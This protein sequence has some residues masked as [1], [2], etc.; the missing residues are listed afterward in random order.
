MRARRLRRSSAAVLTAALTTVLSG[1]WHGVQ[2]D[3]RRADIAF[4]PLPPAAWNCSFSQVQRLRS[5][6]QQDVQ[7]FTALLQVS[8][9]SL[10]LVG[11]NSLGLRL[12]ELS[13]SADG[14]LQLQ[15]RV[16]LPPEFDPAWVLRDLQLASAPVAALR[17]ALAPGWS[18]ETN[19]NGER[20]L[21]QQGSTVIT[22]RQTRNPEGQQEL[23]LWNHRH[24]YRLAVQT[25]QHTPADNR[26]CGVS[27]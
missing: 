26:S 18:L 20:V 27:E 7:E 3:S 9:Q 1:C 6:R 2:P 15:S 5:E 12:F 14:D 16:E 10:R 22:V 17:A 21:S 25:L 24:A 4:T 23:G 11:I 19:G 8:P 13:Q